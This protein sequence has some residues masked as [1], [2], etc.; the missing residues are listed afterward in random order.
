M[1][2]D[3]D[4]QQITFANLVPGGMNP[5]THTNRPNHGLAF[6]IGG[7]KEYSFSDGVRLIVRPYDIIYLPKH[8][9]YT[10]TIISPGDCYAINFD[11]MENI[12][13]APFIVKAKN[14]T[15]YAANFRNAQTALEQK[16]QGYMMKCKAELYNIIY[17]IQQENYDSYIPKSKHSI[18]IPAVEYIHSRYSTEL[19]SIGHLAGMCN[20][21]PEYFR[22]IFKQFYGT[23][24]LN[25]I[26]NLKISRAKELID[27]G[28]YTITESALRSGYTDM[29]HFS[30]EF[31]KATGMCPSEYK[32]KL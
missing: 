29:S 10:V 14:H 19:I 11:I 16:K 26:N 1:T 4:I 9:N 30:R 12:H 20:I 22:R 23:S 18:I 15:A 31:K 32:I 24:P 8:S 28:M 6:H 13:I 7:E 17:S 27:S 3:F 25:Y 5:N 2:C 21:T